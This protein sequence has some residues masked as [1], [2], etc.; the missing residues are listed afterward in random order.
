MSTTEAPDF[1]YRGIVDDEFALLPEFFEGTL[2][3]I[4]QLQ[5]KFDY[6][7]SILSCI[8]S[9]RMSSADKPPY[10]VS[11]LHTEFIVS[12]EAYA[13]ALSE[14]ENELKFEKPTLIEIAAITVGALRGF[15]Y[16]KLKNSHIRVSLPLVSMEHVMKDHDSTFYIKPN[17]E[18]DDRKS[19]RDL[20]D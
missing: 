20:M 18:E 17:E 14:D 1:G 11:S 6:S 7:E 9:W 4:G 5:V 3:N 19:V 13:A 10:L 15:V 16:A 12:E 8:L 2:S